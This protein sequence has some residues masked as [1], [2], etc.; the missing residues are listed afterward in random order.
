MKILLLDI[1]TAPILADVWKLWDEN[2]GLNQIAQDWYILSWAAQWMDGGKVHY[3]D[4]RNAK[5]IEDDSEILNKL[6]HLLDQADVV[7]AHNGD[8]FD[9]PK[10]NARFIRA[11]MPP[12][13]PYR[14]IDT[15]KIA[16]AKFKFTSNRLAYLARYLKVDEG[17]K[18]EHHKYPGHA[19]WVAVRKGVAAAWEEMRKY[20]IQDVRV[21]KGVYLKLRAWDTRHP[22]LQVDD[23]EAG[24]CP[25]CGGH[26]LE[27]RGFTYSNT[28]KFQRYVC[29]SESCG[30][31]SRGKT[32][33]LTK[34]E[35]RE[36]LAR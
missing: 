32:N 6:W 25:V 18:G 35:R 28:G 33:L 8:R 4:Q 21:L 13:S 24:L 16:K 5:D 23:P 36:L 22:N 30:A 14:T 31:W 9:V 15:L 3:A 11:G 10:I 29:T 20:N 2:V 26:H 17:A 1:E 7:I 34:E 27:K 19:L 12:P